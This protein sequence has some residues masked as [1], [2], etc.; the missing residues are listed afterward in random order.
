MPEHTCGSAPRH[1]IGGVEISDSK[2]PFVASDVL[3]YSFHLSK[4]VPS[5]SEAGPGT[6]HPLFKTQNNTLMPSVLQCAGLRCAVQPPPATTCRSSTARAGSSSAERRG[7][8]R[9]G[10]PCRGFREPTVS[11]ERRKRP[12]TSRLPVVTVPRSRVI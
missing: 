2:K 9:R 5:L 8:G 3:F 12:S 11:T 7:A 10:N 1:A 4:C 6:S